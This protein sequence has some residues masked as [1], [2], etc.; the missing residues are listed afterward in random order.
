M[1]EPRT[2]AYAIDCIGLA[3]YSFFMVEFQVEL[4]IFSNFNGSWVFSVLRSGAP[5]CSGKTG[6]PQDPV[7]SQTS[8]V[9]LQLQQCVGFSF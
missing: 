8:H 9:F 6:F 3:Y 4:N 7:R 2:A 5:S 1:N